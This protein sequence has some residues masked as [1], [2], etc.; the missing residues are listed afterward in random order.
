MEYQRVLAEFNR[1]L[2]LLSRQVEA[3]VAAGHFDSAKIC[4]DLF[5]DL[6]Q[7]LFGW[8][9]LRNVNVEGQTNY[10]GIDLADEERRIAVQV[11]ATRTLRKIRETI[12]TFLRHNLDSRFDRLVIYI[13]TT[14]QATYSKQALTK[15]TQ[16]RFEFNQKDDVLD[17]RALAASAYHAPPQR[18]VRAVQIL[19]AYLRGVPVGLD[20]TDFDPP[21]SPT[22]T[23][24][25]NLVEVY[26][27]QKLYVADLTAEAAAKG[28]ARDQR[29][30]VRRA[31]ANHDRRAPS[32]YV[33]SANQLI[34]F[35]DLE[36]DDNPFREVIDPGTITPLSPSEFYE[37]DGD[38]ERLF[39]S[40]LRFLLQ[41]R[42]YQQGVV[43]KHESHV[44]A[45]HPLDDR[46]PTRKE[47]WV[48][49]R[50][51]NVT[52][53]QK[54]M[55][56]N[57]PD[58][59]LSM[60]HLAFSPRFVRMSTSWFLSIEPD[61]YFSFGPRYQLSTYADQLLSGRK[62]LEREASVRN[63]FRFWAWWLAHCDE[64]DL[65]DQ[66]LNPGPRLAFGRAVSLPGAR[67]LDDGHWGPVS[68]PTSA[69]PEDNQTEFDWV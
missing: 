58:K 3:S 15:A 13:L 17:F 4:E 45:F 30:A 34:T 56:K 68:M 47:A 67:Y 36:A 33:V 25:A 8:T 2:A 31:L 1:E 28:R 19:Q 5:C 9:G 37:V 61:W 14:R 23:V 62:R 20:E 35:H 40:L 53:F 22:E 52:V 59:V 64:E 48:G 69:R 44:F 66:D 54:T 51:S 46:K 63:Q 21:A 38:N 39:K 60:R 11:T 12:E 32:D 57:D 27:P 10:P 41:Q 29:A 16:G 42:L 18:I 55:N 24:L 49:Q 65:F 50:Q 43:W 6:F 7:V 26:F